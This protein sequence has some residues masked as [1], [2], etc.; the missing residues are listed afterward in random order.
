MNRFLN[1]L[2]FVTTVKN[3]NGINPDNGN[4]YEKDLANDNNF[5]EKMTGSLDDFY[6]AAKDF[7]ECG[8]Y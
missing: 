8:Y 7:F 3:D 4:S 5:W 6:Y 2:D 1:I